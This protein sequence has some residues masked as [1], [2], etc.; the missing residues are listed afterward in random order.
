MLPSFDSEAFQNNDAVDHEINSFL[1]E[2]AKEV[3][4]DVVKIK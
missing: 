3:K 1:M 4:A 2:A